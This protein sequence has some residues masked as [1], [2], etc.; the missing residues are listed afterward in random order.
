MA[1]G[2]AKFLKGNMIKKD[3]IL[4]DVGI[5]FIDGKIC[6]DVN[7]DDVEKYAKAVTPVP[8]GVGAVTNMVLIDNIIKSCE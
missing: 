6:G 7:F 1:I 5:N 8:G 3:A 4:I 2:K